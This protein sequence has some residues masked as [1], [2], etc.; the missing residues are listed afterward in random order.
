MFPAEILRNAFDKKMAGVDIHI[1]ISMYTY[2]NEYRHECVN[3]YV[4]T[5]VHV[6]VRRHV[7][8]YV[9]MSIHMHVHMYVHMYAWRSH[10]ESLPRHQVQRFVNTFFGRSSAAH[11][12]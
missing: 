12:A 1:Y 8:I 3:L 11:L 4:H 2:I 5:C 7:H 9:H 10:R 6:Y